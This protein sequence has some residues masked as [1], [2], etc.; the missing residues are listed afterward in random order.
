MQSI[1]I[2]A[3]PFIDLA[4]FAANI[5]VPGREQDMWFLQKL[6]EAARAEEITIWTSHLSVAECTSVGEP[7]ITEAV[8]R[9]YTE[10][11]ESGKGGIILT[12]STLSVI[13]KARD[14]AWN[15]NI[16]LAG[17]DSIHVASALHHKCEEFLTFDV[18]ILSYSSQLAAKGM[19]CIN[20]RDTR[21]LPAHYV[22]LS[23]EEQGQLRIGPEGIIPAST[24]NDKIEAPS[25]ETK[26]KGGDVQPISTD[27]GAGGDGP[28]IGTTAESE[29]KEK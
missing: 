14:L 22:Q 20:P 2:E 13:H 29:T 23:L 15:D 3:A 19:R 24:Q 27:T 5:H 18:K 8:K 9:F 25:E 4:K 17:A 10:L 1:Y 21:V 7:S 16:R 6:L 26:P 12:A 11:L 28:P